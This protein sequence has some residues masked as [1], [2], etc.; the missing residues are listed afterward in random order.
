MNNHYIV[1]FICFWLLSLFATF[2]GIAQ[3]QMIKG[4]ITDVYGNPVQDAMISVLNKPNEITKSDQEGKFVINGQIGQQIKV[5]MS[6]L[7]QKT[8]KIEHDTMTISLT[9]NDGY[10][11]L[12]FGLKQPKEEVTMAVGIVQSDEL[13]K[14]TAINPANAL[15]GKIAGLT[16]LQNGNIPGADDPTLL[17]GA[18]GT[19][20]N[21]SMLIL[22]D[23]FER[24]VSFLAL[25]E[26]E[27]VVLLKD[28]A[29]IALYGVR[30]ANGVLLVTTKMNNGLGRKRQIKVGYESGITQAFR[31]PDFLD[32]YGYAKAYNEASTNDGLPTRY[33]QSDLDNYRS[34]TASPY[35]YPN[36]N[37]YD[38]AFRDFGRQNNINIS[39]S[40][41]GKTLKYFTLLDYQNDDGLLRP[42]DL[43]NGY[44]T[45]LKY[46]RINLR[47]NLEI[48]VT[49]STKFE[50]K[51]G[52]SL[53]DNNQ[54]A[55]GA[56][57][58]M[59][60]IYAIPALSFPVK[61]IDGSWGG[62]SS[63]SNNP[64]A[65]IA[66]RG[67]SVY[68]TRGVM[69]DIRIKQKLDFLL[70]GLSFEAAY[71][72]DNVILVTDSKTQTFK[73]QQ[74]SLV[75][76]ANG[77]PI[78]TA[79]TNYGTKSTLSF[80]SNVS[81]IRNASTFMGKL[82]Y[83]KDWGRNA[84]NAALLFQQEQLVMAGRYNTYYH[85]LIAGNVHYSNDGKYFADL[86]MSYGGT[87]TLRK[88]HR[89][90]FFPAFSLAWNLSKEDW[91]KRGG[92]INDLKIRAS[93]GMTGND[94]V[95]PNME[96]SIAYNGPGYSL[97]SS[98]NRWYWAG[99]R[100]MALSPGNLS[101]EKSYK[102][103][104]G[105]DANLFKKLDI[106]LNAFYET[107][108]D[109]LVTSIGTVSSVLG[110]TIAYRMGG[111]VNKQG[112]DADLGF[113]DIKG[114]F[115][116]YF[117]GRFSYSKSKIGEM[118]EQFQPYDALKRTGKSI[119]QAFGLQAIGFFRDASDIAASP[120]QRFGV[121]GPG[122]VK[123]K[124]QNGDQIIN[125]FDE[126]PL[127][128][129]TSYP[130]IYYSGSVGLAY[131]GIGFDALF[132][133]V[134]NYSVY[135]NTRNVFWPVYGNANI[136]TFS[137][138][139]WTPATA[140]TATLPRIGVNQSLNNYRPN[141]IWVMNGSY[142]KLRSLELYYDIPKAL[143][144]RLKLANV[145]IYLRGMNLFSLDHIKVV[146]PEAIGIGYP[147]LTSYNLGIKLG[148]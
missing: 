71:S 67:Y 138:N 1:K 85:Q 113:H 129:S 44:S 53:I 114:N 2:E 3:N 120:V 19:T 15:Y 117:N 49:P 88:D 51:V 66:S 41:N 11:P 130:E 111:T 101:F 143:V 134:G 32:A 79:V 132:Q 76:D 30:G 29:S 59:N 137:D 115:T 90:G 9:G 110:N 61:T 107:R 77:I 135:A 36:V 33:S 8:L 70:K 56:Y 128:Y 34:G 125:Q 87:N 97:R 37:W 118:F 5:V 100:E 95:P 54:P 12:G 109:I 75:K 96:V 74:I 24:P 35:F 123:Y 63:Y 86:S 23:G 99:I 91:F 98:E 106:S 104:I 27:S 127:G 64:V 140:A 92:A 57:N 14:S 45:Q 112:I 141:S 25:T 72:N 38:K 102:S 83:K 126:I 42:V 40:G 68:R 82:N 105:I 146:D 148:L 144:T 17:M 136:S 6:D 28:A 10:I 69:A 133:G 122:D 18:P 16:V 84:L 55:Q 47:T 48:D 121:T 119:G 20:R 4:K 80:G 93:Y 65:M 116:Y 142:I 31:K 139:R 108:K 21:N 60:A 58:I 145:R 39:F 46:N 43:N 131:K 78:D 22:V 26:I 52:A 89:Y 81:S 94:I 62:T 124:D 7:Y 50:V 73:Y 13:S 103:N 147:T